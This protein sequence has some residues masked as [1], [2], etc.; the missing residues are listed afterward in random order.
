M[1]QKARKKNT[2]KEVQISCLCHCVFRYSSLRSRR[3]L[4]SKRCAALMG[5]FGIQ[6]DAGSYFGMPDKV[7]WWRTI[8][9][10]SGDSLMVYGWEHTLCLWL[11]KTMHYVL[12]SP[13]HTISRSTT[14][15]TGQRRTTSGSTAALLF[16]WKRTLEQAL[17]PFICLEKH[18]NNSK[19]WQVDFEQLLFLEIKRFVMSL[20][21]SFCFCF[22]FFG[23]FVLFLFLLC[24]FVAAAALCHSARRHRASWKRTTFRLQRSEFPKLV[25][26]LM[27]HFN[28]I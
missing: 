1:P 23:F 11:H 10:A 24:F 19:K 15:H 14:Q 17:C 8:A 18:N 16:V 4:R 7:F 22:V 13:Y 6:L 26:V 3:L 25:G 2:K 21:F 5:W 28:F 9:A 27:S 12:P 20:F